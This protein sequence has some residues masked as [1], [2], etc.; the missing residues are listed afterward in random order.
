MG[1]NI[2]N[3]DVVENV[4]RL[5]VAKGMSLTAA[6]DAAVKAELE[7]L[8]AER[9]ACRSARERE[10]DE[11][12]ADIRSRLRPLRPGEVGSDMSDFYDEWGL[13]K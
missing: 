13:P 1:L 8:Q 2:K 6:V 12:L 7:R 5:A 3:E 10:L 4:R 9:H 11:L